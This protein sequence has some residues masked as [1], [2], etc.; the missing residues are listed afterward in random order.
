MS[1]CGFAI[2]T[3][4]QQLYSFPVSI[5]HPCCRV[6]PI[7]RGMASHPYWQTQ[8]CGSLPMQANPSLIYPQNCLYLYNKDQ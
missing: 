8:K 3:L 6:R 5:P 1:R 2:T 4:H 7:P